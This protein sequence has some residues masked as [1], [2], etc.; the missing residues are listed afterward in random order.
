M[1]RVRRPLDGAGGPSYLPL[2]GHPQGPTPPPGVPEVGAEVRRRVPTQALTVR[3]RPRAQ[4]PKTKPRPAALT[5]VRALRRRYVGAGSNIK[6]KAG[7]TSE[8]RPVRTRQNRNVA[9]PDPPPGRQSS[10]SG[11]ARGPTTPPRPVI[12]HCQRPPITPCAR[13]TPRLTVE[14]LSIHTCLVTRLWSTS[15]VQSLSNAVHPLLR[16][17]D[18]KVAYIIHA[19]DDDREPRSPL[20]VP[21]RPVDRVR[22]YPHLDKNGSDKNGERLLYQPWLLR[23]KSQGSKANPPP[24]CM[25][26]GARSAALIGRV[27]TEAAQRDGLLSVHHEDFNSLYCR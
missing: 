8:G 14:N 18:Q 25:G 21:Q 10:Q 24:P 6:T 22:C 23:F 17:Y 1:I 12:G 11:A 3:T 15:G 2:R 20:I 9:P 5:A 26:A 16:S 19:E 13:L 4:G 27:L 7:H